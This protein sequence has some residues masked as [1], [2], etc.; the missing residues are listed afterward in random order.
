MFFFFFFGDENILKLVVVWLVAQLCEYV[1]NHWIV[2][3]RW[4]TCMVCELYLNKTGTKTT[5]T[6][7]QGCTRSPGAQSVKN[8]PAMQETGFDPWIRKIPWRRKWQP[9]P[10]VLTKRI[11]RTEE[12][13][14]LQST[15]SQRVGHDLATKPTQ[16]DLLLGSWW[17]LLLSF[18]CLSPA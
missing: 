5:H 18:L 15:G 4:L 3:F 6:R 14:R 13:G 16:L 9:T 1:K 7:Q 8:L 2:Q 17:C 10:V 12:S 11:P